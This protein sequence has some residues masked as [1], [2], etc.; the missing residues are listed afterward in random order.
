MS[1]DLLGLI[2][3]ISE[4]KPK[5]LSDKFISNA[6]PINDAYTFVDACI[7]CSK[8]SIHTSSK[9]LDFDLELSNWTIDRLVPG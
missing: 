5:F 6:N 2:L 1:P 8:Q 4:E 3:P 7:A 9:S